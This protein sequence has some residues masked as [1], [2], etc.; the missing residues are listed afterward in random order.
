[1][2]GKRMDFCCFNINEC[3]RVR[4][5]KLAMCKAF[6]NTGG[7]LVFVT[8][9]GVKLTANVIDPRNEGREHLQAACFQ[10]GLLCLRRGIF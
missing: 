5:K 4:R 9:A 3:S 1:M 6:N 2:R 7:T 8:G 10:G